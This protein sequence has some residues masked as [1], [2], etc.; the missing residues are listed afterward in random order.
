[1]KER[2]AWWW[3]PSYLGI[4]LI[5]AGM[6]MLATQLVFRHSGL[7]LSVPTE[8]FDPAARLIGALD[9]T[10]YLIGSALIVVGVFRVLR[11]DYV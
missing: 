5:L 10:L 4:K 11:I 9:T 8:W 6:A 2:F 1:M 3:T 7:H